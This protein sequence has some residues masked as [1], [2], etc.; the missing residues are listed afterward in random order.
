[1]KRL[2]L[3]LVTLIAVA[4]MGAAFL[5]SCGS[6][7]TLEAVVE[8]NSDVKKEIN[9]VAT[10]SGMD[11][12]IKDNTCTFTYT[13]D[14]DLDENMITLYAETFKGMENDLAAQFSKLVGEL[15]DE[16][17]IDGIVLKV[18]YKAKSGDTIYEGSFNKD[19]VVK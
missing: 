16:T 8:S 11:V 15:E 7:K 19:G 2:K 9:D 10:S 13:I 3:K 4:A 6:A 17:K 5:S 14:E 1:M 18:V 12:D